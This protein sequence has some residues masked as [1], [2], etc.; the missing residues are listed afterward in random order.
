RKTPDSRTAL[1][2]VAARSSRTLFDSARRSEGQLFQG[3]ERNANQR[4]KWRDIR[5]EG[6]EAKADSRAGTAGRNCGLAARWLERS[7]KSCWLC[8]DAGRAR[9]WRASKCFE[10]CG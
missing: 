4:S 9:K 10:V 8:G 7:G 3:K 2:S 5:F 6:A 1:E